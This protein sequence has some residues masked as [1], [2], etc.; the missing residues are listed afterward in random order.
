MY[1]FIVFLL[2]NIIV[3]LSWY[4]CNAMHEKKT[5]LVGPDKLSDPWTALF[6]MHA[7]TSTDIQ[8]PLFLANALLTL[9]VIIEL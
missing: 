4:S 6:R 7:Y 3:H 5:Y 8:V 9:E 2:P 1:V